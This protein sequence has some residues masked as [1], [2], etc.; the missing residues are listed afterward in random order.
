MSS[1][2]VARMPHGSGDTRKKLPQIQHP[3]SRLG[4]R[5]E[6]NVTG[7]SRMGYNIALAGVGRPRREHTEPAM[8]TRSLPNLPPLRES[9]PGTRSLPRE[10]PDFP[11]RFYTSL[12]GI[13]VF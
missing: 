1:M 6:L 5:D 10:E 3:S 12:A 4:H 13:Y 9:W 7:D 8:V 11:S 2:Q